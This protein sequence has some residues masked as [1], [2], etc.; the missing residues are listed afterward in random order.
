MRIVIVSLVWLLT[1]VIATTVP[2]NFTVEEDD[3]TMVAY[4]GGPWE[5]RL[6]PQDHGRKHWTSKSSDASATFTFTGLNV[7]CCC[8]FMVKLISAPSQASA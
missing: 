5:R 6:S 2:K 1:Q 3:D 8:V 7:R 4:H